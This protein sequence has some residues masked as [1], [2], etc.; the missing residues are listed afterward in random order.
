VLIRISLSFLISLGLLQA[1]FADP[2]QRTISV[3][4]DAEIKVP[5]DRVLITL[6]VETRNR[7]LAA[8]K[9]RND[10]DVR[11]VV[12]AVRGLGIEAGDLQTDFVQVDIRY[13]S[14]VQTV[15]DHYVVQKAMAVTLRDVSK[16]ESLLSAALGAGANHVHDIEFYTTELRKYRDQARALAIK[17]AQEKARDMAA[18]AGMKVADK[19]SGISSYSYGGGSWYGRWQGRRGMVAQN[20]VQFAGGPVASEGTVALGRISVTAS[21]NLTFRLE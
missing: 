19:P 10:A 3:T 15:I 7:D 14:D 9:T 4:G 16:F 5:P 18:V 13:N 21:V 6:G 2:A 8:A 11:R 12:D 1:Q 17:A 20:V